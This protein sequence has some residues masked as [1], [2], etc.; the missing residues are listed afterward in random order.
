M[1]LRAQV[2]GHP[3]CATPV[4]RFFQIRDF[5]ATAAAFNSIT[6]VSRKLHGR[7]SRQQ[8]RRV[9]PSVKDLRA[10]L[11]DVRRC[12]IYRGR[13]DEYSEYFFFVMQTH[14]RSYIICR[15]RGNRRR[16]F[17]CALSECNCRDSIRANTCN[18]R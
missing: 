14:E 18:L 13:N 12:L 8:S 5:A 7:F 11:A 17:A 1:K 2:L 3:S 10:R 15:G 6:R 16:D 4:T 9:L